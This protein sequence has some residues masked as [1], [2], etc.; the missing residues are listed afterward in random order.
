MSDPYKNQYSSI[1][2]HILKLIP[3][4]GA[5]D[6]EYFSQWFKLAETAISI[7]GIKGG[8]VDLM[9]MSKLYGRAKMIACS[10]NFEDIID[11]P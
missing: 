8:L 4:F 1:A 9:V 10:L 6:D 2:I 7:S 3:T 11:M 5:N